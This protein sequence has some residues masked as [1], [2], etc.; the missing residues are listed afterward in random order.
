VVDAPPESAQPL[1]F[2]V[3]S[4]SWH[5]LNLKILAVEFARFSGLD[6]GPRATMPDVV[7][8]VCA[9]ATH[10]PGFGGG[11]HREPLT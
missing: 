9:A 6:F 7:N 11:V 2:L 5:L 10:P 1:S 4:G 3:P 8:T